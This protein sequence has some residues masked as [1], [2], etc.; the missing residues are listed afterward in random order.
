MHNYMQYLSI[1][2][3]AALGWAVSLVVPGLEPGVGAGCGVAAGVAISSHDRQTGCR[4]PR[5]PQ[6]ERR[7]KNW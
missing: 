5:P 6:G 2:M 4:L 3:G 1:V 7:S